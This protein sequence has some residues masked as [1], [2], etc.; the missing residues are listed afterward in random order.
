MLIKK[1]QTMLGMS[2]RVWSGSINR[3]DGIGI[4]VSTDKSSEDK[5]ICLGENLKSAELNIG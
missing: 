3:R 1:C 5:Q 2:Y 4:Y